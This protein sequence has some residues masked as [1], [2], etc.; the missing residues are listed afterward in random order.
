MRI[1]FLEEWAPK[2][3]LLG[4]KVFFDPKTAWREV[5]LQSLV[6]AMDLAEKEKVVESIPNPAVRSCA[7]AY[8][9]LHEALTASK[10]SGETNEA[11]KAMLRAVLTEMFATK[12]G[13]SVKS[14][15]S[16]LDPEVLKSVL[17]GDA[18]VGAVR[19]V[20]RGYA[21]RTKA[22]LTGI[23]KAILEIVSPAED[24][25]KQE[26]GKGGEGGE[27]STEK[28]SG[29]PSTAPKQA[30]AATPARAL[31]AKCCVQCGMCVEIVSN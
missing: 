15:D 8:T 24:S 4:L 23:V 31:L 5:S 3:R 16:A 1:A 27:A 9:Q 21:K 10:A 29:E 6:S 19:T 17:V 20:L 28:T 14:D 26:Q 13:T 22:P 12:L 11:T 7:T 18:L 25:P 2:H 30:A